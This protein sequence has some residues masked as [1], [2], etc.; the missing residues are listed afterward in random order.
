MITNLVGKLK[1]DLINEEPITLKDVAD[2]FHF[3]N[4]LPTERVEDAK[5]TSGEPVREVVVFAE[6]QLPPLQLTRQFSIAK[7]YEELEK[8]NSEREDDAGQLLRM[9]LPSSPTWS[10]F[11]PDSSTL[12]LEY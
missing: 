9:V 8:A 11:R 6:G 5:T 10:V 1:Q 3:H 12:F 2:T 7:Y 4:N